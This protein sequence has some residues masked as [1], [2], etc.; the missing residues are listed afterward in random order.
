MDSRRVR[1]VCFAIAYSRR[2]LFLC[3]W[4]GPVIS[5][6]LLFYFFSF[7]GEVAE[8]LNTGDSF[9]ALSILPLDVRWAVRFLAS[10]LTSCP[11]SSSFGQLEDCF[12]GVLSFFNRRVLLL[13]VES[14]SSPP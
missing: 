8:L 1:S 6:G 11:F 13:F 2:I 5:S 9:K 10:L 14:S 4:L 12:Q 3:P 7:S